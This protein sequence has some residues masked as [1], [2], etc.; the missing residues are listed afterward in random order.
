[1]CGFPG[2]IS[3]FLGILYQEAFETPRELVDRLRDLRD[4]PPA[5]TVKGW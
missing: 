4:H 5:E 3:P 1:M 2:A